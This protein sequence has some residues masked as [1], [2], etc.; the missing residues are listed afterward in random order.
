MK[1][2]LPKIARSPIIQVNTHYTSTSV[3]DI[4]RVQL[5]STCKCRLTR[6]CDRTRV[7]LVSKD[8]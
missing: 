1:D 8:R 3:S 2:P 5:V 6:I 4:A 7:Q